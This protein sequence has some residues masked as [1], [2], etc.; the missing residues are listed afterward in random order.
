M[1]SLDVKNNHLDPKKV[2]RTHKI[3]KKIGLN[4]AK[5]FNEVKCFHKKIFPLKMPL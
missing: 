3:V 5:W 1:Y 2:S 4:Y